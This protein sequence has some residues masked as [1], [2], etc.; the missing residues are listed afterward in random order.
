VRKFI[1]G[2][3]GMM[4]LFGQAGFAA[5]PADVCSKELLLA[6]FP[7]VFVEESMKRFDVPEEEWSGIQRDL[8]SKDKD[9]IKLVEEKGEKIDPN[10][11]KDPKDRK[12]AIELFKGTLLQVFSD[13]MKEHGITD[14][15]KIQAMLTDI[16]QRKAEAFS[17][18]MQK[19]KGEVIRGY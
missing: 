3:M 10:P 4:V 7:E 6:Y 16:Q 8:A 13:V 17:K 12:A 15:Q 11:L 14:D 9:M 2:W 18:C 5:T 1:A 19:S